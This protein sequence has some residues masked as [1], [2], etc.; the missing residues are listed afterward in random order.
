MKNIQFPVTFRF[1]D[2]SYIIL[3]R[4][5][6]ENMFISDYLINQISKGLIYTGPHV[7]KT[8]CC[9]TRAT[10]EYKFKNMC[11]LYL[12]RLYYSI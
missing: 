1:N 4:H 7:H 2:R 12:Y 3:T 11:S 10:Y 6:L 5:T 9:V 8:R